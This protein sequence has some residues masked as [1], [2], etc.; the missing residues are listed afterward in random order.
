M[1]I[2]ERP[3]YF[4]KQSQVEA[5]LRQC[6]LGPKNS[7]IWTL[8]YDAAEPA[9]IILV[10]GDNRDYRMPLGSKPARGS[11]RPP[12]FAG[13]LFCPASEC[14]AKIRCVTES[15]AGCNVFDR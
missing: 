2:G 9:L 1:I 14:M 8:H 12:E 11:T 4:R 13:R 6:L 15:E 3:I 7:E 10:S 5:D